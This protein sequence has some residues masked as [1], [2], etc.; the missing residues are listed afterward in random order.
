MG[1]LDELKELGVEGG[2]TIIIATAVSIVMGLL[3]SPVAATT[4]A[5]ILGA[6]LALIILIWLY[7]STEVDRVTFPKFMILLLAA[8]IWGSIIIAFVPAAANFIANLDPSFSSIR[9]L[10]WSVVYVGIAMKIGVKLFD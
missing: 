10:G 6:F 7:L 9:A 5:P 3:L 8:G 1:I 4:W 2:L